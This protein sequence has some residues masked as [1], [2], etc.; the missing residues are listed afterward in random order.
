LRTRLRIELLVIAAVAAVAAAGAFGV[1]RA[2]PRAST[3]VSLIAGGAPL[4]DAQAGHVRMACWPGNPRGL[5]ARQQAELLESVLVR[6]ADG[7]RPWH[8]LLS[9]AMEARAVTGELSPEQLTRYAKAACPRPT[10]STDPTSS[11]C[12]VPDVASANKREVFLFVHLPQGRGAIASQLRQTLTLSAVRINGRSLPDFTTAPLTT[13]GSTQPSAVGVSH[14]EGG[15]LMPVPIELAAGT[16]PLTYHVKQAVTWPGLSR[17]LFE[18]EWDITTTITA[19]FPL[20]A[21]Q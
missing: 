1:F 3:L 12:R 17:P 18:D 16:Y 9:N 14:V 10:I 19:G 5:T 2:P 11:L 15:G 4:S 13:N 21:P 8:W 7:T 20:P 6:Q